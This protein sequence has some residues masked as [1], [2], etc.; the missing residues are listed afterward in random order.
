M[1]PKKICEKPGCNRFSFGKFCRLHTIRQPLKTKRRLSPRKKTIQ[2]VAEKKRSTEEMWKLFLEIWNE[3]PH[4]CEA[5]GKFLG[6]EPLSTM[7]HHLLPKQ[8]SLF[9]QYKFCKWNI[10]LI[11]PNIHAAVESNIDL[12]PAIKQRYLALLQAHKENKL[13]IQ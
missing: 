10:A 6:K 9:P 11:D 3:R 8:D 12:V 2:E 5:T 7:F 13:H 1:K 4:R